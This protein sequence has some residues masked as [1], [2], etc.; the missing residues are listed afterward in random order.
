MFYTSIYSGKIHDQYVIGGFVN[1]F[2]TRMGKK[3]K[4]PVQIDEMTK[5]LRSKLW[6][7]FYDFAKSKINYPPA[8]YDISEFQKGMKDLV[9]D[10]ILCDFFKQRKSSSFKLRI[11]V[12]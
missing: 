4:Q 11:I 8:G 9:V 7:C 5:S 3:D 10:K 6:N 12:N 2:S 1:S